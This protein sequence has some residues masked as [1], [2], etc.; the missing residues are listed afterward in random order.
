M[1]TPY[2]RFTFTDSFRRNMSF[3]VGKGTRRRHMS[4]NALF[5]FYIH[6]FVPP[7][8]VIL[9]RERYQEEA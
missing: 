1:S 2:S 5:A 4:M 7:Q 9:D 3:W 8:Y 6:R